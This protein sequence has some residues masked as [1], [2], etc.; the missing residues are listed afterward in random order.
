MI[1]EKINPSLFSYKFIL[2]NLGLLQ[3]NAVRL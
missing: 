2:L 1:T 3:C